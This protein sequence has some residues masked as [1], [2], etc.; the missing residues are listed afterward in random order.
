MITSL[1]HYKVV[2]KVTGHGLDMWI[3]F[4]FIQWQEIFF[5]IFKFSRPALDPS[6]PP[7]RCVQGLLLWAKAA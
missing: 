4:D 5:I 7:I 2:G 6:K 3:F 1:N